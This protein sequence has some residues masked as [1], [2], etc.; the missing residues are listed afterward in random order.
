MEFFGPEAHPN[1]GF[2]RNILY[3]AP[4]TPTSSVP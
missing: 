3:R 1:N 4:V 2:A